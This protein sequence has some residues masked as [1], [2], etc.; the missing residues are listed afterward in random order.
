MSTFDEKHNK[1]EPTKVADL[2]QQEEEEVLTKESPWVHYTYLKS[3]ELKKPVYLQITLDD[4]RKTV[5]LYYFQS[6]VSNT[7]ECEKWL[8]RTR[9]MFRRLPVSSSKKQQKQTKDKLHSYKKIGTC[10]LIQNILSELFP[11]KDPAPRKPTF[12]SKV[13]FYISFKQ[14]LVEIQIEIPYKYVG[15]DYIDWLKSMDCFTSDK[16]QEWTH[17]DLTFLREDHVISV[18]KAQKLLPKDLPEVKTQNVLPNVRKDDSY[19]HIETVGLDSSVPIEEKV[20]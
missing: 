12:K 17:P 1:P 11:S 15:Q 16:D 4:K 6:Q 7:E 18:V 10:F 14:H 9:D 2:D 3:I 13:Q 20:V 19:M 8:K 5:D